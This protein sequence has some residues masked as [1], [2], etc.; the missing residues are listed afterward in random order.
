MTTRASSKDAGRLHELDAL[1]FVAALSVVLYHLTYTNSAVSTFPAIGAVTRFGYVGVN[2]FF[3]ISG[4]VILWSAQGR[5]PVAFAISRFSRLYPIFWV[6]IIATSAVLW[7]EGGIT[8][9]QMLL[10]ATMVSGYLGVDYVDT[11]YWT[12]QIELKFYILIFALLVIGQINNA[13]KWAYGWLTLTAIASVTHVIPGSLILYPYGS[14]F[15]AGMILFQVWRT[16]LTPVRS[17]ALAVSLVLSMR[18]ASIQV[19][20]FVYRLTVDRWVPATSIVCAYVV[21]LGIATGRIKVG[22]AKL[23]TALGA[24]TYPLYLLHN[25]IGREIFSALPFGRWVSLAI[26]MF[27]VA[28]MTVLA[29]GLD[30]RL[31]RFANRTLTAWSIRLRLQPAKERA[32]A[33][34]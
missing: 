3:M 27:S 2:L 33:T 26:T 22:S 10:N 28:V 29:T 16:G 23:C 24:S 31:H 18:Q 12:L 14:Y 11:V 20:D 13:E 34:H 6:A 8:I 32:T 21:L 25:K 30:R 4:F 9:R 19:D 5:S 1:R 15:A 7:H 17:V